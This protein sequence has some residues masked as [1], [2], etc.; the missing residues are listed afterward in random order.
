MLSC[1]WTLKPGSC[2]ANYLDTILQYVS[3]F[4]FRLLEKSAQVPNWPGHQLQSLS[5]DITLN[6]YKGQARK[7]STV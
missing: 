1:E 4:C 3:G 7:I 5:M 2:K 6:A